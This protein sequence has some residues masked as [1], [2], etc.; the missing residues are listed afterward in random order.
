MD[1]PIFIVGLPR[2]GSTLLHNIIVMNPRIFRLAEMHFLSPWRKDFRYFVRKYVG[3]LSFEKNVE[4]M[5]D[6]IFSTKTID[7]ITGA[8][9]R[10]ENINVVYNP[11]IKKKLCSKIIQSDR[12]IGSIFKILIEEITHLSGYK[13]CCVKFPVYVNYVPELL[14]WYPGCKVVHVTRDPRAIAMS[15]KNDPGGTAIKLAK[16]PR[17]GFFMRQIRVF[18]VIVQYIW[19]SKLH[20]KYKQNNNYKLIQYEDLLE[21]PEKIV[22]ELCQFIDIDFTRKILELHQGQHDHQPSSLTKKKQRKF[23]RT[24]AYRWKK[25]ISPL[26]KMIITWF[27]KGSMKKFGYDPQNHPI[28]FTD[29]NKTCGILT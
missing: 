4:K 21:N 15:K 9:W 16:H 12:S 3:D 29:D 10:F 24:A 22:K 8:F 5:I 26:E 14:K 11:E 1:N 19:T 23:D 18:F 20:C 17:F 13:R 27:T 28:Y 6:M 2:S 7:G 25:V